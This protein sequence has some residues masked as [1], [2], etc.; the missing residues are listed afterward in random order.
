MPDLYP[1]QRRYLQEHLVEVLVLV[2]VAVAYHFE[3][4]DD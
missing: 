2:A 1:E 4:E 3:F